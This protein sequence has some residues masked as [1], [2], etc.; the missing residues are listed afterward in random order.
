MVSEQFKRTALSLA[1]CDGGNPASEIWFCGL[2]HG[3]DL[4]EKL[5]EFLQLP[6]DKSPIYSWDH[7]DCVGDWKYVYNRKIC[8]FL[9]YFY[10]LE[11]YHNENMEALVKRHH[12]LYSEQANGIGFKLNMYPLPFKNRS[13]IN[14]E[15]NYQ[16]ATGFSSF[17]EYKNWCIEYRGKYFRA[18][19]EKYRPKLIVC[20]GISE[21][22]NFVRCFTGK[23]NFTYSNNAEIK[24]AYAKFK[25]TL[26][27]VCPFF[28][29]SSGINS[30][31]KMEALVK[32][33]KEKLNDY[34]N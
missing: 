7:P 4:S 11:L 33:I 31:A 20:T 17:S 21:V 12:I 16:K 19:L 25:E 5:D 9:R 26:I 13:S 6:H 15:E 32:D 30:Y 27:C 28:T 8:W 22:N 2:E 29:N 1:G 3:Y 34:I 10:H 14:W 23:D 24:I 18:L